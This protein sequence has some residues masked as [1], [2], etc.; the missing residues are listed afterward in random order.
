GIRQQADPTSV[1]PA[2]LSP[3]RVRRQGQGRSMSVQSSLDP[4]GSNTTLSSSG[5][6]EMLFFF[7]PV[8]F[9]FFL[10]TICKISMYCAQL[11]KELDN[12]WE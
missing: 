1:D 12:K 6:S 2:K 8:F 7:Y 9:Y 11:L 10:I 4:Y 5:S 3:N